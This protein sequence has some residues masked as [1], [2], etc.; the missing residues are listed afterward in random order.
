MSCRSGDA[1][2]ALPAE[3]GHAP[4]GRAAPAQVLEDQVAVVRATGLKPGAHVTVRAELTDGDDRPWASE[5]EF[6]ADP[7][8]VVD[9]SAQA[10]AKGSYRAISAMGLVWSMMPAA[11]DVHIYRP[12]HDLASQM[13][14]FHL[15]VDGKD[16]ATAQLQQKAVGDGVRQ[17]KLEGSLRGLY[18]APAGEGKHAGVLVLGGSEGGMQTRRAAWLASH[19]FAALALCYFHCEG[20]PQELEN[21]PLEYFGQAL[22]WMAERPEVDGQRL[23]VMGVSRGGE[24]AL[25]LGSMDPVLKAVVAYVPANVRYP[26]CC[27]RANPQHAG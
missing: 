27:G 18:F 24:L 14:S 1:V 6:V 12:M 10:P 8:G 15:L 11:K 25:Q 19:G 3:P 16:T 7:N 5:A 23:A 21:I 9:T 2:A 17:I 13:I 26:A 22:A 20:R 4:R